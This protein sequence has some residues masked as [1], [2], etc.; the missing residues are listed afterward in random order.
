MRVTAKSDASATGDGCRRVVKGLTARP[1]RR[2]RPCPMLLP[3]PPA[4]CGSIRGAL[5]LLGWPYCRAVAKR[6][7]PRLRKIA[8]IGVRSHSLASTFNATDRFDSDRG[9]PPRPARCWHPL[10]PL[11]THVMGLPRLGWL[12]NMLTLLLVL[13]ALSCALLGLCTDAG[14]R[15][16]WWHPTDRVLRAQGAS[17]ALRRGSCDGFRGMCRASRSNWC[18][19]GCRSGCYMT[20]A[21]A[22][23]LV[24]PHRPVSCTPPTPPSSPYSAAASW[25]LPCCTMPASL[26]RRPLEVDVVT[27]HLSPPFTQLICSPRRRPLRIIIV[28]AYSHLITPSPFIPS[29]PHRLHARTGISTPLSRPPPQPPCNH[30]HGSA[31]M[32][33]LPPPPTSMSLS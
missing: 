22:S 11:L 2:C 23:I 21:D 28:L 20:A 26:S 29:S 1:C 13:C 17:E 4:V 19:S 30:H 24:P 32:V 33:Q 14:G 27:S 31:T 9:A 10:S 15:R 16:L 5:H 18:R 12:P 6:P 8:L 25:V 7:L 3:P